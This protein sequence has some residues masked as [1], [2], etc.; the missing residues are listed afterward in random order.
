MMHI[1]R[2]HIIQ[3]LLSQPTLNSVMLCGKFLESLSDYNSDY[4]NK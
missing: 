4:S 3:I 2:L 1:Y